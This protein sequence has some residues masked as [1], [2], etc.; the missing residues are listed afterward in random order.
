MIVGFFTI[1]YAGI[2]IALSVKSYVSSP[3]T[4]T[5]SGNLH[6]RSDIVDEQSRQDDQVFLPMVKIRLLSACLT[7]INVLICNPV[8]SLA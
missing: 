1:T 6:K 7:D 4:I 3:N 5:E 8:R 2:Q